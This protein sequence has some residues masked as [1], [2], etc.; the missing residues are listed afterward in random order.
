MTISDQGVTRHPQVNLGIAVALDEGLLT[1]V[2]RNANAKTISQLSQE[3]RALVERARTNKFKPDDLGGGTFTVSNL[4]PMGVEQFTAIINPPEAAIL[5]VGSTLPEVTARNGEIA[6]R[7]VMR[8][9][10]SSDHRVIDGAMAARFLQTLKGMLENP[11]RL[12]L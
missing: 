8:V 3:V 9:T 10:L 11:R 5:A 12:V 4:G 6:V 1:P 2:V 7:Q